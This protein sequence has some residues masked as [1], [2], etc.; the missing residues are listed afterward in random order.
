MSQMVYPLY[1][2]YAND[3]LF[4]LSVAGP[5]GVYEG[6]DPSISGAGG[7]S[8]W[9]VSLAS[10]AWKTAGDSAGTTL[11]N[12]TGR[13]LIREDAVNALA[14]APPST[15]DRIDLV[16]GLHLYADGPVDTSVVPPQPTG[17]LSTSQMATYI[18]V[19][20]TPAATP[21]IPAVADPYLSDGHRPVILAQVYVPA[22]G[23]PTASIY[24]PNNM[25]L[26]VMAANVE[27]VVAAREGQASLKARLDSIQL[28]P[29]AKGDT[30]AA[31]TIAIG[32]VSTG[33]EGSAP[34]V[35]DVGTPGAAILN[36]TLPIGPVGPAGGAGPS[37]VE[38]PGGVLLYAG[39]STPAGYLMCDGSSV[40]RSVYAALYGAIGTTYGAGDGSTTF[41]LPNMRGV[42][43]LGTGQSTDAGST[44]HALASSGG[45]E[46][47]TLSIAEMPAHSHPY[48]LASMGASAT[49]AASK[50][51]SDLETEQTGSVGGGA[52]HNNMPPFLALNF[53]IKT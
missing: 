4:A 24:A 6:L 38:P 2:A 1:G 9:T 10:G 27:E 40:S 41:N 28:T 46:T 44:N 47:R 21:V 30:G 43:P 51:T 17:Q 23:L 48:Q 52:A 11:T 7:T 12:A 53:L 20:G 15:Q 45:E 8:G 16:V 35:N 31:A 29:G 13:F 39:T 25:R 33:V 50:P 18:I 37:G 14:I 5:P 32:T 19:Q 36:F 26:E 34:Q 3:T 49:V 42:F 22:S